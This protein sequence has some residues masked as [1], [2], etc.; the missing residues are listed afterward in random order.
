MRAT[1]SVVLCLIGVLGG[2]LTGCS[3]SHDDN[4]DDNPTGG[5]GVTGGATSTGSNATVGGTGGESAASS[6]AGSRDIAAI[7]G[8]SAMGG[9]DAAG[10][11]STDS[12]GSSSP[13]E[14]G[15]AGSGGLPSNGGST[16]FAGVPSTGAVPST[17]GMPSAGGATTSG[18]STSTGGVPT[19]GGTP[20]TGGAPTTGGTTPSTAGAPT[21]GGTP[22]TAGAPTAGGTP[23]A[24][25]TSSTGGMPGAG[26]T[27]ST[28]GT[29]AVVVCPPSAGILCTASGSPEMDSDCDGIHD[30]IEIGP[31]LSAPLDTDGDGSPNYLDLDSD[32]D[33]ITDLVEVGEKCLSPRDTDGDG[34]PDFRDVDSDGNG[35]LD[36]NESRADADGDGRVDYADIDDDGDLILDKDEIG[37]D[38]AH[39]RDTDGDGKPD[40]VDIDSDGDTI[41]DYD[42]SNGDTDHDGL[43]NHRDLDADADGVSDRIEAGDSN[44]NT[45]PRDTDGDGVPDFRDLDSDNDGLLD[46]VEDK[47]GDGITDPG[48]TSL[49]KADTDGDGASD[50]VESIAGT[51]PLNPSDNPAVHGDFFFTEPYFDTPSPTKGTLDFATRV[52]KADVFFLIDT[53]GSMGGTL[54][55]LK[56][57]LS[58]TIIP[59]LAARIASVGVG[60]GNYRDFPTSP[61]GSSGDWPFHLDHRIMTVSTA[62]G[63]AS[64]QAALSA[65]SLG[66]GNDGPESAWEALHQ[67]AT[68]LGN[69]TGGMT[70]PAFNAATAYPSTPVAGETLGTI[71]GVGFRTGA[72]PVVVYLTDAP[73]HN[74]DTAG[75]SSSTSYTSPI[76]SPR[77]TQV[78]T[79]LKSMSARVIGVATSS[80]A[81]TRTDQLAAVNATGAIVP[82]TAWGTGTARPTGCNATQCCTGL[83]GAGESP[84]SAGTC[85]LSFLVNSSGSGLGTA[86]VAAIEALTSFGT[87]DISAKPVDDTSDSVDAVAAFV[88]R[89]VANPAAGAPCDSGLTAV[90]RD[91]DGSL[92]TFVKVQSGKRVCFDVI[93]K[94]NSTVLPTSAPQTF[95]ALISVI[96]DGVTV[97][98]TR[99]VYFLVPAHTGV[100]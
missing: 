33:S 31:N 61:F 16:N 34:I 80:T 54:D 32:G 7:A 23:G 28:G 95:K 78:I 81:E 8:S 76:V 21:A 42:E 97:L 19:A 82:P 41:S 83:S 79:E 65:V 48:E 11:N 26:G 64:V 84:S 35:I 71:P 68:G 60:I 46:V 88:Q 20:S 73:G 24:G 15:N 18:G 92:D 89:V 50:L 5:V 58:T 10:G 100:F 49:T 86:V 1:R 63:I 36:R 90:D 37:A 56:S 13:S 57:A 85:P 45:L 91:G 14:G 39:P 74:S 4:A 69:A 98:D 29:S 93:P 66:G 51:D 70:V 55:G 47:D 30:S 38:P 12:G 87:M 44:A 53:T 9:N 62:V 2:Q 43:P 3:S 25:G 94:S 40:F 99:D 75:V 59:S 27:S 72:L 67:V 17:A 52:S 96:G 77:S 6:V 22:S